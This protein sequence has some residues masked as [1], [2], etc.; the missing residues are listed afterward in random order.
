MSARKVCD[1]TR[2]TADTAIKTG[3]SERAVQRDARAVLAIVT[4]Y[5]I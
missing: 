3:Q 4:A 2:I 5:L 1:R